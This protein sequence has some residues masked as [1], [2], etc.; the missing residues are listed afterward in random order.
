MHQFATKYNL[1]H[2]VSTTTYISTRS[3]NSAA[4]RQIQDLDIV[5]ECP[6]GPLCI[7]WI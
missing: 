7:V 2:F 1:M 5:A 4:E 3:A 6:H